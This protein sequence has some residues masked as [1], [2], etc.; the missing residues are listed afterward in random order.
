MS[1]RVYPPPFIYCNNLFVLMPNSHVMPFKCTLLSSL[2]LK[3]Y[4][5]ICEIYLKRTARRLYTW[6]PTSWV[7]IAVGE[8]LKIFR[9][10]TT[11]SQIHHNALKT[12]DVMNFH[13]KF[14]VWNRLVTPT[15]LIFT[16]TKKFAQKY[17][18]M[19]LKMP[20]SSFC[21]WYITES[22]FIFRLFK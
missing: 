9:Q 22:R 18:K 5:S 13:S 15:P 11:S 4:V 20:V 10:D 21:C 3:I 6:S 8:N 19:I 7:K 17:N 16:A 2:G 12:D 14:C 1:V